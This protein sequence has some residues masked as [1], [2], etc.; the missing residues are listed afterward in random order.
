MKHHAQVLVVTNYRSDHQQSMLRFGELLISNKNDHPNLEIKEIYPTSVF[1]NVCL[2]G[3]L[4]KWASYIDK[5]LLFPKRL[6]TEFLLRNDPVHLVHIIDHSNAIYLPKLSRIS[7][8]K[9]IVTCHDL[10]AIR[11]AKGD[12]TQAP[13]T[14]KSG[15]LLQNWISNSLHHADYY[16]CDSRQTMED[17]KKLIPLSEEKS[18]VFHLGTEAGLSSNSDKKDLSEFIPF[19]TN[20]TNYLLHVGSAAWYK[21]R[22]AVIRCFMNAHKI[23]TRSNLKLV[24]VGPKPQKEELDDE[25]SNWIKSNPNA[26]QSLHNLSE[27]SLAELYNFAKGLVYPSFIEGFGWPPLEAAVRGCPVITT[28]TGAIADLL[29][30]YAKYVEAKKQSTIDQSVQEL[31]RSTESKRNIMSLPTH[32][33]CRR[34]YYNLYQKM[35]D[36]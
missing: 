28:R 15:K 6:K 22:K 18:S 23:L 14:S 10:I 7:R 26:I 1:R 29:G 33:D 21:N 9:K 20:T 5:Y 8:V 27:N 3:K 19:D 34:R 25:L 4:S 2:Y 11:A 36:K 17:L 35:V 13:K 12:F 30:N 32:E 16:A 24:L 31:L